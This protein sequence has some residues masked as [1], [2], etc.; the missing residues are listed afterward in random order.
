MPIAVYGYVRTARDSPINEKIQSW[1]IDHRAAAHG[2]TITETFADLG[3]SGLSVP[4]RRPE[5]S[6]LLARLQPSDKL[7]IFEFD[8]LSRNCK[9]L[10]LLLDRL[11]DMSVPVCLAGSDDV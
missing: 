3:V 9:E 6:A 1:H 2:A 5:F 11:N 7:V 8:R 10:L 4:E